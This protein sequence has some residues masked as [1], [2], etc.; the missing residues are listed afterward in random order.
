MDLLGQKKKGMT[1][2][3]LIGAL[4][5]AALALPG[6]A[7]AQSGKTLKLILSV[8]PGAALDASARLLAEKLRV[9]LDRTVVIDYKVGGIGL[10]AG[11]FIRSTEPDGSYSISIS[12]GL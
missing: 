5:A 1:R 6:W 11:E 3:R 8:P 9:S 2:R 4:G 12:L 7:Q 10:S